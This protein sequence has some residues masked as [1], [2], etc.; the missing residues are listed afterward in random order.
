MKRARWRTLDEYWIS[1][2][3]PR[4]LAYQ[5]P[6]K[7]SPSPKPARMRLLRRTR[8]V[9]SPRKPLSVRIRNRRLSLHQIG[10]AHV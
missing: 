9:L 5:P 2:L 8:A 7:I 3:A 1:W 4:A 10:R 6:P